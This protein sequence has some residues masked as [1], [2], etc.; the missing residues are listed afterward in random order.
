MQRQLDAGEEPRA[1]QDALCAER[2]R[3]HQPAA[4]REP[5]AANTGTRPT[6]STTIGMSGMLP[7]EPTWPPPSLPCAMMTSA[8]AFT[9]RSASF[10]APAM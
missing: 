7:I 5:P 1:E 6:A 4:V 9:A 8:P 3:R 2:K 10:T